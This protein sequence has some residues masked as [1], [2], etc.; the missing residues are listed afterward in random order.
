MDLATPATAEQL[1]TEVRE[2][3]TAH[4]PKDWAGEGS[5]APAAIQ[6]FR[7]EWR[8]ALVAAHLLAPHWPAAYGGR[9]LGPIEYSIVVE[10][11]VAA[12]V[13]QYPAP[14]DGIGISLL[15][16]AVLAWGTEEQKQRL[17]PA[18]LSGEIRWAQGYSEP[19]AGSDLFGLKTRA[20]PADGGFVLNGQ[21]IWQTAGLTANWIFALVR[22][23][24]E[25]RKSRGL[26]FLVAEL[27]QPGVEVHGIRNL[28][29]EPEFCE[30]FFRDA[31][32]SADNVIGEVGNGAK[33]ALT[34]L[35]HERG[36]NGLSLA[37]ASRIEIDRLGKLVAGRGLA[38]DDEIRRRL[39]KLAADVEIQRA[40]ALW[41]LGATANSAEVGPLSSIVKLRVS[42]HRQ[43]VH[44]LAI[45]VLGT[46]VNDLHGE[47]G[48][49]ILRAQPRGTDPLAT[50]V[51]ARDFL[52][53]RAGTIYG[54]SEQIQK[55]TIGEQVL[56][57]PREPA[58][59]PG[60]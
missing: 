8:E 40:F 44:E 10:E 36:A 60:A 34:L 52:F 43:R 5:L 26:T 9:G 14:N 29:G 21:K 23:N 27:D 2:F 46:A 25:V 4:V 31:Y 59:G 56:G 32:A 49:E 42:Q 6:R 3:I 37:L 53:A 18:T 38:S 16:P 24:P 54:G 57:L 20:E 47:P 48:P 58:A 51:W 55:N 30:V 33:V 41:L 1:R 12:G 11:F 22:T 17:L 19:E 50:N 13:P 28:N 7:A 15:G 39:G 35:G 45:D